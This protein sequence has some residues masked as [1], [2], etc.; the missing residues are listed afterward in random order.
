MTWKTFLLR[1]RS[2]LTR[3]RK[4]GERLL[5]LWTQFLFWFISFG[6]TCTVCCCVFKRPLSMIIKNYVLSSGAVSAIHTSSRWR[7]L[8]VWV[9][10]R[11]SLSV[12][13][14]MSSSI[15]CQMTVIS[16]KHQQSPATGAAS[17]MSHLSSYP[18]R[19]LVW[20]T[21]GVTAKVRLLKVVVTVQK[22]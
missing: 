9:S 21:V 6:G 7:E 17:K 16:L 11:E 22:N 3:S 2:F 13:T 15:F 4:V 20:L 8:V 19:S 12:W 10:P 5:Q 18:R 14:T 1:A